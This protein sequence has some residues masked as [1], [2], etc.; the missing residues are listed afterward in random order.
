MLNE[1]NS[2]SHPR[3]KGK[4]SRALNPIVPSLDITCDNLRQGLRD[5]YFSALLNSLGKSEQ[6][7]SFLLRSRRAGQITL[8]HILNPPS[9][10]QL[11]YAVRLSRLFTSPLEASTHDYSSLI[12]SLAHH[13]DCTPFVALFTTPS[14]FVRIVRAVYALRSYRSSIVTALCL[15]S[16]E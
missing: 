2:P 1:K 11:P 15:L 6:F 16:C 5:R 9:T 8:S 12:A 7:L 13:P 3:G 10:L 4:G 14:D